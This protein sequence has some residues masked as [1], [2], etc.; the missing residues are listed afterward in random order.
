[1]VGDEDQ[2]IYSWRGAEI[3]NLLEFQKHFPEARIIRLEQNYRSTGNILSAAAALIARNTQRL[4]KTLWTEGGA[5][6]PILE[7]DAESAEIEAREIVTQVEQ[8]HYEGLPYEEMAIFYRVNALSRVYEEALRDARV[9]YR[10]IGGVGFYD[11]AEIKD[12]LSYLQLVANPGHTPA[13]LRVINKPARGIGKTA[14]ANLV[15]Y[16]TD[17]RITLFEAIMDAGRLSEAGLK[18]RAASGAL[19]LARLVTEW[20][21]LSKTATLRQ[22]AEAIVRDTNYMESLGDPKSLEALSR[23]ENIQEFLGALDEY[24][25][26]NVDASLDIYLERVALR[27]ADE[28]DVPNAGVSLMTVHNAKG[29]EFDVVFI[30]ALEKEV[31]P[32]ARALRDQGH[33]QEERRLF[34]VALTRARKRV[35]VSHVQRRLMYG[36]QQWP[37]PSIFFHEIPKHLRVPLRRASLG[38]VPHA[39]APA[40]PFDQPFAA[41]TGTKGTQRTKETTAT[42]ATGTAGTAGTPPESSPSSFDLHPSSFDLRP[43]SLASAPRLFRHEL[44]GIVALVSETG[45]GSQRRFVVRDASGMNH[46]LLASYARLRPVD[47]ASDEVRRFLALSQA[48]SKAVGDETP[49]SGGPGASETKPADEATSLGG[50]GA[51]ETGPA[52]PKSGQATPDAGRVASTG[53]AEDTFAPLENDDDELPF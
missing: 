50:T 39:A 4:G 34:Y 28:K 51:P 2:S 49:A 26:E 8:M 45:F 52:P 21:L 48:S 46:T 19:D 16:C 14:F 3:T 43:S 23:T 32:N 20:T 29:L 31:F 18:G 24:T 11:R 13:L 22:L 44:L 41:T 37:T 27:S 17:R 36:A 47:P 15:R 7:I 38:P 9:P 53:S 10:V 5:G 12:L 6:D 30:V 35:Y 25:K 33:A 42:T 40:G 1:V